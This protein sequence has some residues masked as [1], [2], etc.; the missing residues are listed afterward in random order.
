[1]S[2]WKIFYDDGSIF[3][4]ADGAPWDAPR[5]GVQ[6]IVQEKDGDYEKIFGRDHFYYEAERGGWITC[7]LFGCIDHLM[8][9]PR[10]CLLFGRQMSDADF[11]AVMARVDV[12]IGERK[13]RYA[14]ESNLE[15]G[16]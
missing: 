12:E 16:R 11:R 13:H 10:Q 2:W 6:A 14:R 8:R 15:A 5:Q 1:M 3:S 9:A 7:D 4:Q